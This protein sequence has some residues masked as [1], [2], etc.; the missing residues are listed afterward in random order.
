M[1]AKREAEPEPPRPCGFCGPGY[2]REPG[3][4]YDVRGQC[5][6][7]WRGFVPRTG[8]NPE[9]EWT[10]ACA[11]QGHYVVMEAAA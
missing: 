9:G 6:G 5:R 10:C 3:R 7:T 1:N 4:C 11:A 2:G 8:D